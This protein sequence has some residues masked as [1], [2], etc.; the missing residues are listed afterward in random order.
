[1]EAR[2]RH[3]IVWNWSYRQ[4]RAAMRVLGLQPLSSGGAGNLPAE[5]TL[6]STPPIFF[7]SKREQGFGGRNRHRSFAYDLIVIEHLEP[8]LEMERNPTYSLELIGEGEMIHR[9]HLAKS[10]V[11]K[12]T[13]L[14]LRSQRQWTGNLSRTL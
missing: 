13:S 9:D 11:S 7:K 10:I 2:R 14:R 4:L 1:M 12:V 3:Q 5:P 6:Q 8:P